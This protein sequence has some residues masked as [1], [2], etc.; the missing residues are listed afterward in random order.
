VAHNQDGKS[1]PENIAIAV[2][3]VNWQSPGAKFYLDWFD[4]VS[5]KRVREIAGGA[6][7]PYVN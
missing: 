2:E 3:Q 5:G 7:R 6:S 4:P 1:K